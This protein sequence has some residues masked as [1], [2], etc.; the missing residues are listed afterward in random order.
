[1]EYYYTG[2]FGYFNVIILPLLK[3]YNGPKLTIYT[4]PD[5]IYI[6]NNLYGN[7]FN[8]IEIPLVPLR[9]GHNCNENIQIKTIRPSIETL[10]TYMSLFDISDNTINLNTY[11]PPQFSTTIKLNE[12]FNV[13]A[14]TNI[15]QVNVSKI[16]LNINEAPIISGYVVDSSGNN[17]VSSCDFSANQIK[18]LFTT[19]S[20]TFCNYFD[21]SDN[22]TNF[23][24]DISKNQN[25]ILS[26]FNK[27]TNLNNCSFKQN[28]YKVGVGYNSNNFLNICENLII[29][30]NYL[31]Q[32]NLSQNT[33]SSFLD[34]T[35]KDNNYLFNL[36]NNIISKT[37]KVD[38]SKNIIT[39]IL[40]ING[41]YLINTYDVSKN[42]LITD[43]SGT[44]LNN[45][46][47]NIFDYSGNIVPFVL[48]YNNNTLS[49]L[50]NLNQNIIT[51]TFILS[52]T[53]TIDISFNF[54]IDASNN[55]IPK[56]F[57]T[58]LSNLVIYS[59][60]INGNN[61]NT[62]ININN[63]TDS[64]R[65][66]IGYTYDF[67]YDNNQ[68]ISP[69][70]QII[71]NSYDL[72]QNNIT[73]YIAIT[74]TNNNYYFSIDK[75]IIYQLYKIDT[76]TNII[77]N[78]ISIN[79][80]YL[81]N[82]YN[83]ITNLFT[84][85]FNGNNDL[86]NNVFPV[87]F[88]ISGNLIQYT[89]N[90]SSQSISI[91]FKFNQNVIKNI[92]NING[93]FDI[94]NNNNLIDSSN[95]KI[96]LQLTVINTDLVTSNLII[97]N[98][99]ITNTITNSIN[100]SNRYDIS[101]NNYINGFDYKTYFNINNNTFLDF[102]GNTCT[103]FFYVGP[104][105]ITNFFDIK[106][107]NFKD[108]SNNSLFNLNLNNNFIK[109][110]I[111]NIISNNFSDTSGNQI[112][113]SYDLSQNK[114]VSIFS[115]NGNIINLNYDVI[116]KSI[117]SNFNFINN[118]NG[119]I[120]YNFN[121]KL[122]QNLVFINQNQISNVYDLSNNT[123]NSRL[124][125]V[126][127]LF[128]II[129]QLNYMALTKIVNVYEM[130]DFDF[131][132]NPI[133]TPFVN[134]NATNF[135][136]YF[137]RFRNSG[138]L[139]TDW[140]LRNGLTAQIRSIVNFY[141]NIYTIYIVGKEVVQYNYNLSGVF[142]ITDLQQTIFYLRNCKFLISNDSGFV[143]FAKNCGCPKI[144]ILLPINTYHTQFTPT[145]NYILN[146]DLSGNIVDSLN[147]IIDMNNIRLD[148]NLKR[149]IIDLNQT[150]YPYL[151][152][153][154]GNLLIQNII[155]YN[156]VPLFYNYSTFT[157][158]Y[159]FNNYT[160]IKPAKSYI[161]TKRG[162]LIL[163]KLD[164]KIL[165][166]QASGKLIADV[167]YKKNPAGY[168]DLSGTIIDPS[169]SN[170]KIYDVSGRYFFDISGKII[171]DTSGHYILNVI[172]N[173]FNNTKGALILD[174][175]STNVLNTAGYSVFI[176]DISGT[177]AYDNSGNHKLDKSGNWVLDTSGRFLLNEFGS[178]ILDLSYNYIYNPTTFNNDPSGNN[179]YITNDLSSNKLILK[180]SITQNIF[181]TNNGV[182][183][184]YLQYLQGNGLYY[185]YI[186]TTVIP[187]N[188][189]ISRND[190]A[191]YL[192]L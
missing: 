107:F 178:Y 166:T 109:N 26:S 93:K 156:G 189:D 146:K 159:L 1:M 104:T 68:Y 50:L 182:T 73:D 188:Y 125:T 41:S 110:T 161:A 130:S 81:I 137:P 141:K 69:T 185:R 192:I 136:C 53:L 132:R 126:Q 92:I 153:S 186:P 114:I 59:L 6:L 37:C 191:N 70:R 180:N 154:S 66:I 183:P 15:N 29:E 44:I 108:V 88:D 23:L 2:Q 158:T 94:N 36:S 63:L 187:I 120:N 74:K 78:I 24:F 173:Y 184:Y 138:D 58:R 76:S 13:Y 30:N 117:V 8:Y 127:T 103:G 163:G 9:I 38:L 116:Q 152:D 177:Y 48:N 139:E 17:I 32:N 33:I 96:P 148:K 100:I 52:G 168:I 51:S 112:N 83:I 140:S 3:N 7:K 134:N 151:I 49:I 172:A 86:S 181:Y 77:T 45:S 11:N 90:Y 175:S 105:K 171:K 21:S 20:Y 4:F 179:F 80:N 57:N 135:I 10:Y 55:M 89:L 82:T 123:I 164:T 167:P 47:P 91:S 31:N 28:S 34:S 155:N 144:L 97:T 131:I 128:K 129:N 16:M 147:Q 160:M 43:F 122:L 145:L 61:I 22:R 174:I 46:R 67:I 162:A 115:I 98:N 65:K 25:T 84:N 39:N 124:N 75:N 12:T 150:Y 35:Q 143:D 142:R 27:G 157:G 14:E 169:G 40:G 19:N 18:N 54:F 87:F 95:N 170:I 62:S 176:L 72:S 60:T 85:N 118:I 102:E 99:L 149:I 165:T 133:T 101:N 106:D 190:L 56:K 121:N 119:I 64:N 111:T 113:F 71:F 79:N 42:T 5:Y